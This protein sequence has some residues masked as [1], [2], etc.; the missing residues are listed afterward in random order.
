MIPYQR[1]DALL[2][3]FDHILWAGVNSVV[4][5]VAERVDIM[6]R[7]TLPRISRGTP[8]VEERSREI[9]MGGSKRLSEVA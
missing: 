7:P 5:A 9:Q 6:S 3:Q 2:P 1:G 8:S 4:T